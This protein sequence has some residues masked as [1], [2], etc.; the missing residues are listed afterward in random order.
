MRVFWQA[1]EKVTPKVVE[2][3][4][5]DI[6]DYIKTL[7]SLE[8]KVAFAV[9]GNSNGSLYISSIE[10]GSANAPRITVNFAQIQVKTNRLSR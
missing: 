4:N 6:T 1:R 8:G 3:Y 7:S 10:G 9:N 5:I 2:D